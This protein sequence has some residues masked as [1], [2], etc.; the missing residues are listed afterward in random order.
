MID[1]TCFL[2]ATIDE[3]QRMMDQQEV[4]AVKLTR[5]YLDRVAA[6]DQ[7]LSSVLEIN[8]DAL[9]TAAALDA[10]RSRTGKRSMLHGIPILLKDNIDTKDKLH[11]SAGALVLEHSYAKK[12]AFLVKRLR[13]AGAV[14]LGKTNM[15][16]W[17][18]F[19]S[20]E[21]MPSGYSS[22]GGQTE[23]PYG[24]G[25]FDVGG[26]SSGSGAAIA[27]NFAVAAVGTETS[28]SILSP[29]SQ[30]SIVGI[31]PTVGLVS[32]SGIIPLS[33]TQDTAGPMAR[34][35]RDAVY[36]LCEMM[37]EDEDDLITTVCPYQPDQLLKALNNSSLHEKRIGIV[38]EKVMDLLGEEKGEV[39]ETALKQLSH[40][41]AKV[42]DDVKIP[43][44]TRKWSYNVLTYEFKA[45]VNKYLSELDSSISVRT[46]TDIIDWNKNHHEKALKY[47][48]SLLIEADK[49]SGKLTEKD[50][51][52]AL[53]ED[54]YFS[55]TE[56]IDAVL[57]EHQLD[58]IVFPN[59]LGAAIPAK[60]GY[61]SITVPAG[62]TESGEPVGITFTAKAW[63]EPL[64]IEIA[65]AFEKLTKARKQ[66]LL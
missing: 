21:N 20:T 7:Q 29:S 50:Y 12:D 57:R 44:S 61:P 15:S 38:R 27:A 1:G 11:T 31:K 51:L 24:I 66:P 36:L 35:V 43:S 8:P 49:T 60:A 62:Y 46:L 17:A 54:A 48:Q 28:G 18:Y 45:N 10:E 6:Y 37:G 33:H 14:I 47:G 4:T 16:E 53:N 34:T 22:R 55:A 63:Q 65:E 3:L 56:G 23:N 5:Y 26:S 40:A 41:G 64:L 19:M 42:I 25:K 58:V 13:E 2:E 52:K 9:H 30:N 59:N 32:R 39:Y